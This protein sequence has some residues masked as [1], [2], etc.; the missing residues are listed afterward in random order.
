MEININKL[1]KIWLNIS[2]KKL[3]DKTGTLLINLGNQYSF[4]KD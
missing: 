2:R 4:D 1:F 3:F